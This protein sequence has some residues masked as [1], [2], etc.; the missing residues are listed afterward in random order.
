MKKTFSLL[1]LSLFWLHSLAYGQSFL[2]DT[3]PLY[4][5]FLQRDVL[6]NADIWD[7]EPKIIGAGLGFTKILGIP[8]LSTPYGEFIC[9]AFGGT[10]NTV[11]GNDVPLRALTSAASPFG[12]R[13]GYG[14]W[15]IGQGGL[16]VEFSWP[17][18]PS[19]VR[20]ENFK[21]ILNDGSE[22]TPAGASIFPNFEYNERSTVVLVGDFGNRLN[23]SEDTSALYPVLLEIVD[24]DIPLTLI[25]LKGKKQIATG[26]TFGDNKTPMTAYDTGNGPKLCAAKISR[27]TTVGENGPLPFR[28]ALPN[29]GVALYGDDAQY[30]L[31]ILTTGGFSPDGVASVLPTDFERFFRIRCEAPDGTVIWITETNKVYEYLG[32][33]LEVLGLAELGKSESD[34]PYTLAYTE[35]HD[36]QIDI[37]L[38]GDEEAMHCITHV[39]I[40]ASAEY[41]PFYNPGG[42]GNNPTPGTTY[43]QPGPEF[44]QP[45]LDAI[46][47][48]YTVTWFGHNHK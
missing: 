48:P 4:E 10:W 29:D 35:D 43:T 44:L 26:F 6:I 45:V 20:P 23:P 19:T 28:G 34:D 18:Q 12:I 27:M 1:L 46:D 16:P 21:V 31:R 7:A 14:P 30:R 24:S 47:N 9:R 3:S 37:I 17:V 38:R 25:G 22:I 11:E 33:E 39:H 8:G 15:V 32:K 42:P 13:I 36:N 5:F 40:P 41:S 2:R